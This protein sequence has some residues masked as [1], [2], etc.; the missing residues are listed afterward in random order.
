MI[1]PKPGTSN[2]LHNPSINDIKDRRV[3]DS[4]AVISAFMFV[5]IFGSL[6]DQYG[7]VFLKIVSVFVL[8]RSAL[9]LPLIALNLVMVFCFVLFII[10][11]FKFHANW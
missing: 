9:K 11:S 2:V 10:F 4:L 6:K 3:L 5:L 1:E 7:I 8:L